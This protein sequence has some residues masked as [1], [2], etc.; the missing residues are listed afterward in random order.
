MPKDPFGAQYAPMRHGFLFIDKPE[1]P[2]SHDIVSQIRRGLGEKSIGHLGTLDP[3][4]S[5]LL[6][7]AVGKKA[8]KV[9]ELFMDLEKQY[10]AD[11]HLGAISST[12][13]REGVIEKWPGKAGWEIPEEAIVRRKIA[14][15]LV[16]RISQVPP[17]HSAIKIGGERAY[18]MARAGEEVTMPAR[19]VD[20]H[21][22]N[23]LS[24]AYPHVQV[25]VHCSS[26]TYIRSLAHDLGQLLGCGGYLSALRRTKVGDWST[27]QAHKPDAIA[28]AHVTPLKEILVSFPRID[29]SADEYRDVQHGKEINFHIDEQA[30]GWFEDLPVA[31]LEPSKKQDGKAHARKVL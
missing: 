23:V 21:A 17:A 15:H 22:C 8:L 7:L 11:I 27:D 19:E 24:Y 14:D 13:D 12:Y 6:V 26:G 3:A 18:R 10:V 28:W 25:R 2:T 16:G 29:L 5:G 1:G 31:V 20:I 9:I 4:A 30:I